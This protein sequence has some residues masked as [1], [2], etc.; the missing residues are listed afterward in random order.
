MKRVRWIPALLAA[1]LLAGCTSPLSK[2][3]KEVV[4]QT[5]DDSESTI[6]PNTTIDGQYYR[7]LLPYKESAS[8]GLIVSNIYS[9]YDIREAESGLTRISRKMYD[10]E[11]YFFQEG[12]Y[13]DKD[14]LTSWLARSNQDELGLNP[15]DKGLTPTQ[16]AKKAPI[17]LAHIVEQDYLTQSGKN[18]VK[19]SG[20]SIGLALNSVYY[21]QKE[22]FGAT[23]DEPIKDDVLEAK[24]KTIAKQ[25]VQRLRAI[26]GLANV[27]ITVGL[28]KQSARGEIIPGTYIAYSEVGEGKTTLKDWKELKETYLLF[29]MSNPSDQYREVNDNFKAFKEKINGYFT[30]SANI[31]GTGYY[32]QDKVQSLKIEI[33]IKFYGSSEITGFTQFASSEVL[34]QFPKDLRVE[35]S[36]T[37]VN[38]PE[39]LIVKESNATETYIHLYNE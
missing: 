18:K 6:I 17:Y 30:N 27:P 37:S 7:T 28:F 20:I 15:S 14:T 4:T 9:N 29:P 13:L 5:K 36:V 23:Y 3:S 26:E 2:D 34:K 16:R 22:D 39:A 33:P 38:G 12:Q 11:K 32:T 8:R 19:L 24:G 25:V 10:P 35:L 31:I 21:Y 1:A